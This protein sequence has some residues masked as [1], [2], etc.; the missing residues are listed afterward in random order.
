MSQEDKTKVTQREGELARAVA[1]YV[2]RQARE[3]AVNLEVFCREHAHLEPELRQAL[4]ALV[5]FDSL[6]AA[7]EGPR[8]LEAPRDLPERL[9]GHKILAEIGSGGMG[10]VLLAVDERLGRKVAIKTLSSRFQE[11]AALRIRFMQEARALAQISHPNIV[12]IHSLGQADEPPHFVMEYLEGAPLTEA[13]QAFS[14]EQKAE[15]MRKVALAVH[16]LHEHRIIHRDL[17]PGNILVGPGMEPKL[18]DFGLALQ[19]E[20][21][22]GRLTQV[23]EV[24]GTPHYFSPEHGR[25]DSRLDARSDVFSLG[26][27]HYELLTGVLP[28]RGETFSEQV[29]KIRGEHPILPRR[30][31]SRVPGDLQTI[32]MKALEKRPENRYASA[33]EMA[34]DLERFLAGEKVLASPTAYASLMANKI[35]DH[36]R[37]LEG[38]RRDQILSDY[39]FDAFRKNYARLSEP[40]DAW[41][42]QL[43]R[44]ALP[45]V[46]LY[47][48]AWVLVVGAALIFLF[49]FP[50]LGGAAPVLLVGFAAG[51]MGW[52]G[53]SSWKQGRLRTAIAFLLAFC[54]LLPTFLLV[55]FQESQVFSAPSR[56][57]VS[58]EL[59]PRPTNAQMWWAILL[60]LPAVLWLRRFTRS[61]VFSLVLATLT[62]LL[63]LVTLLRLG[64]LEWEQG[65]F[66]LALLPTASLFFGAAIALERLRHAKDSQYVYPLAVI[67]TLAGLS[68]AAAL[69]EP[70][71]K[72]LKN[73]APWTHGQ[74]EYFFIINTGIYYALHRVCER[75]QTEQLRNVAKVFR[76]VVPGHILTSLLLLGLHATHE[77]QAQPGNLSLRMEARIF[78]I[79]L[80]TAACLLIFLSIPKQMKNY[81]VTGLLF[82]AAGMYRL[83]DNLLADRVAWPIT[84]MLIGGLLMLGAVRYSAIKLALIR[85]AR[86]KP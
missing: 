30:L 31:N 69:Y 21:H 15:L 55:F 46:S 68:G 63:S 10:R 37:E 5:E 53:M 44:I 80:P 81:L 71:Q 32:C 42:M 18:L 9:S 26:T 83:Q 11:N 43:R 56:N 48:G 22:A 41:I 24:L 20:E 85:W 3:E 1:E 35:E 52:A 28:F 45:Q 40:E 47:L 66:Y 29:L 77:W 60:S 2:D 19:E 50:Q 4:A 23:G 57:D 64:A 59:F 49:E 27:I 51:V 12:H 84:L 82:L 75:F 73:V 79:L 65:K 13:A 76:F 62:A 54:L 86:R 36:L 70:L 61:S 34:D 72:L 74:V 67:F 8:P 7:D 16:V 78:E 25:E 58:L 17:K 33:R 6:S 14:L 39:E 38:W